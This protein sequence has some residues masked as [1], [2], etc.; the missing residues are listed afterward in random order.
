MVF[1]RLNCGIDLTVF[2]VVSMDNNR[3]AQN[4]EGGSSGLRPFKESEEGVWCPV[5]PWYRHKW[6]KAKRFEGTKTSFTE[7]LRCRRCAAYLISKIEL[8]DDRPTRHV[9][10]IK[11]I[12][13]ETLSEWDARK[14]GEI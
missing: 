3:E 13:Y 10:F 2:K 5:G 9:E 1:N 14:R 6:V 11:T 8:G 12:H 4:G 7:V